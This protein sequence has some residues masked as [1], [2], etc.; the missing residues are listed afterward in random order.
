MCQSGYILKYHDEDGLYVGCEMKRPVMM[1]LNVW[2]D[3]F[4]GCSCYLLIWKTLWKNFQGRP[5]AQFQILRFEIPSKDP[6][7]WRD[8]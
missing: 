4:E 7:S 8:G 3:L 2:L 5:N 6:N 1:P